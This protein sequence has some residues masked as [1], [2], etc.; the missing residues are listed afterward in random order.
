M[1]VSFA[2]LLRAIELNG[3]AI[4]ANKQALAIGRLMAEAPERLNIPAQPD[5]L[6]ESAELLI[7]RF[8]DHLHG[9]QD[10]AYALRF[11][12][13]V[14]KVRA[15]EGGREAGAVTEAAARSLFRLMAY[16]DEYEVARLHRDRAFQDRLAEEFEPG[17]KLTYHLAPPLFTGQTDARGRLLKRE[18][19]AWMGGLLS[20]LKRM[21]GLRGRFADPFG[22]TAERRM[23][24]ELIG[25]YEELLDTA[26]SRLTADNHAEIAELLALGDQIRGYG[27][28]KDAAVANVKQQVAEKLAE[29]NR[30]KTALA[31]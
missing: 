17:F 14:D 31:A 9:Y 20:V 7:E 22:H 11:K 1:P 16:K 4:D 29:L 5:E 23:E 27:P 10:A 8:V 2:G 30:A 26:L 6:G 3:V 19:G 12:Q 21:K 25:W 13:I 15:A 18:Y 24:R 28:V